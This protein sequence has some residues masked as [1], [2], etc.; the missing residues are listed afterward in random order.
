MVDKLS[1]R[2]AAVA[3][4]VLESRVLADVGT[5]HAQL[6]AWLLAQGRIEAALALD[7]NEGPLRRARQVAS[8]FPGGL[9]VRKSDGLAAVK[10]G[11]VGCVSIAGMGGQTVADILSRGAEVW[12][13]AERVV[14]QP[15]GMGAKARLA[16][17]AGG[18]G[19]VQACLVAD[20]HQLYVVES[21]ERAPNEP[22]WTAEDLR[23]GRI[24]RAK[25][26]PL[27]CAWLQREMDDID[28]GLQ[29]LDAA[30]HSEHVDAHAL[31]GQ[32][33]VLAEE[34]RRVT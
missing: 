19:C 30:G 24:I 26:D 9:H 28:Q 1:P 6:P 31:R 16:L 21:W 7:V 15:Q 2:L 18:W 29:R 17:L 11:E 12:T 3:D 23:W 14:I 25:P 22:A 10:P 8:A 32:R 20:R 13:A 5:D 27:F 33:R 4:Q 34:Y